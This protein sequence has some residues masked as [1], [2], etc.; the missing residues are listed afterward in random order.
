VSDDR[1]DAFLTNPL[2]SAHAAF[3]PA[4]RDRDLEEGSA[5]ADHASSVP[6]DVVRLALVATLE[7]RRW[8]R[9]DE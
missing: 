7:V 4:G 9:R 6:R 5:V 3:P 1:P 8:S 2:T